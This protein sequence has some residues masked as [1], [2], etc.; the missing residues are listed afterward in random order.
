M[1]RHVISETAIRNE[2][3]IRNE[4]IDVYWFCFSAHTVE[5]CMRMPY[6]TCSLCGG[7][8]ALPCDDVMHH[9]APYTS[10]TNAPSRG[11]SNTLQ[12]AP[13][14]STSPSALP[15]LTGSALKGGV[16]CLAPLLTRQGGG[17]RNPPT[18]CGLDPVDWIPPTLRVSY[19]PPA[20]GG[21]SI[22]LPHQGECQ[23]PSRIRGSQPAPCIRRVASWGT[24]EGFQCRWSGQPSDSPH[25]TRQGLPLVTPRRRAA[26]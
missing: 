11:R 3:A 1:N 16:Y 6:G 20:S 26:R 10:H 5:L 22:S 8:C 19:L 25:E 9:Q 7:Q 23:S 17:G 15:H 14:V 24:E 21:V 12:P 13:A 4:L 18:S 2:I